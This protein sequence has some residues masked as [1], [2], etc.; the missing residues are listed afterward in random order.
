MS[1]SQQ[2]PPHIEQFL[3]KLEGDQ[4]DQE[5]EETIHVYVEEDRVTFVR[6]TPETIESTPPPPGDTRSL[7]VAGIFTIL[8]IV[9]I[10]ASVLAPQPDY[11]K[12]FTVTVPGYA[13]TPVQ[14]SVTVTAQA[15]G[16]GSIAPTTAMGIVSFYNGAIYTQIIPTGTLLKGRDGIAVVTDEQAT[17]PPAAQTTPPTYGQV[18]VTAHA[19]NPGASGNIV[20]GDIN[21]T[22]CVTSVIAQN[23]YNFTGGRNAQ[24]YTYVTKQDVYNAVTPLLSTLQGVTPKLFP[25]LALSPQCVPTIAA[26]PTVGQRA[27]TVSV[28]AI[29]TCTAI[30]YSPQ[31]VLHAIHVYGSRYGRGTLTNIAYQVI[32][33]GKQN[34]ITFYVTATWTPFVARHVWAGK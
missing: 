28:T 11:S 32:S 16:K 26:K 13:L 14:K 1:Q 29:V 9:V 31:S 23:P 21:T 3:H 17:I 4:P 6:E 25:S 12:A 22:C 24:S 30:S 33:I 8:I 15:T 19:V 27:T 7:L 18:N 34:R 20:A 5:P 2:L 10:V